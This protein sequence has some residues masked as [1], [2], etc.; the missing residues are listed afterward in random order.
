MGENRF[1]YVEAKSFEITKNAFEVRIIERG[2]KHLSNVSMG[3]AA[4]HW[5]RDA[6]LEVAKLSN[7]QNLFRSFREGHKVYVVQK[8]KNG[9]GSFVSVT[10]LGD[11]KSRDCVII[12][13]GR[14]TWGWRGISHEIDHLLR[15][16]VVEQQGANLHRPEGGN[17]TVV[18][19]FRK[20]FHTFKDAVTLGGNIPKILQI[21][22]GVNIDLN[23]M[24]NGLINGVMEISLK[25]ILDID[26]NNK[27]EVRWAGVVDGSNGTQYQAQQDTRTVNFNP[28]T[29]NAVNP[30][31]VEIPIRPKAYWPNEHAPNPHKVWRPRVT[32]NENA[33]KPLEAPSGSTVTRPEVEHVSVHSCDTDS[34]ISTHIVPLNQCDRPIAEVMQGI[35]WS[36]DRGGRPAIGFWTLGTAG[37]CASWWT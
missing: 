14:D 30:A 11:S 34:E 31:R 5:L 1:F 17:S 33:Q 25:L 8:Q 9:R 3:F 16:K 27:W 36:I 19:H 24:G 32:D 18:G 6:L 12:P 7:D 26:Q 22:T 21:D 35:G 23:Q 13:E 29:W 15:P 37:D 20:D 4:A 28:I 10:V 2:R